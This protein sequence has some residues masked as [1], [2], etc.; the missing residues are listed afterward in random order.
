MLVDALC[1]FCTTLQLNDADVRDSDQLTS[2]ALSVSVTASQLKRADRGSYEP[3]CQAFAEALTVT[4]ADDG[5][6]PIVD[7]ALGQ[8]QPEF[9]HGLEQVMKYADGVSFTITL[10][11]DKERLLSA[12]GWDNGP[13]HAIFLFFEQ[14]LDAL[15]TADVTTQDT[16]LFAAPARPTLIVISKAS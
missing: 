11:I 13:Y 16:E 15:L 12:R 6:I 3:L 2:Y 14:R 4:I 9:D 1:Q 7:I 8:L 5:D 10:K